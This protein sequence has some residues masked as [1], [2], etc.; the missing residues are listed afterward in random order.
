[1]TRLGGATEEIDQL[2]LSCGEM[3][4]VELRPV[5]GRRGKQKH[6]VFMEGKENH[7]LSVSRVTRRE[8]GGMS[9][10]ALTNRSQNTSMR[11]GSGTQTSFR[12]SNQRE[13]YVDVKQLQEKT[14]LGG[15]ADRGSKR[16]RLEMHPGR[17]L[18]SKGGTGPKIDERTNENKVGE[19]RSGDEKGGKKGPGF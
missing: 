14:L 4:K 9:M 11:R 17:A 8:R 15:Q 7:H 1:V 5:K 12:E 18:L 16:N 2:M 13:K 3:I 19:D 10:V 6:E